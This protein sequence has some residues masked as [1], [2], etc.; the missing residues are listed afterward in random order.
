VNT[1]RGFTLLELMITVV[2]I[3]ILA[4]IALPQYNDYVTRAQLGEAYGELAAMR[5]KLEQVFLDNRSYA[6]GCAAGSAAPLPTG[7][8][9]FNITCPTLDDTHYTVQAAAIAG[10]R[11]AGFQFTINEANVRATTAAPSGWNA[12]PS[13]WTNRKGSPPC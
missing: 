13:C 10:T 7:T 1:N 2:V 6:P 9:Y 5:T 12:S 11:A 8:K 4:A 3:S